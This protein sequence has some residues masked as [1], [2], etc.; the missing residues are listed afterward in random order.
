MREIT[1]DVTITYSDED[2]IYLIDIDDIFPL[3]SWANDE[4]SI[5]R[6]VCEAVVAYSYQCGYRHPM[7]RVVP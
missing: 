7:I 5:E 2:G 6:K 3:L 4:E 1:L